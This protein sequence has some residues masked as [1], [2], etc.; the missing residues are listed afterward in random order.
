MR[1]FD[2][3]SQL[4][5]TSKTPIRVG[6]RYVN[7]LNGEL[8]SIESVGR[9]VQMVIDDGAESWEHTAPKELVREAIEIGVLEHEE[10]RCPECNVSAR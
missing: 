3:L 10:R 9:Q 2:R 7:E 4:F 1:L 8:V 5:D 6:H